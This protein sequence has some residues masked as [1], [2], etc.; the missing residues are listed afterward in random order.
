MAREIRQFKSGDLITLDE[1]V[2]ILE[3]IAVRMEPEITVKNKVTGFTHSGTLS[4]F[5][6]YRRLLLEPRAP[7]RPAGKRNRKPTEKP[8]VQT[9][10]LV[11]HVGQGDTLTTMDWKEGGVAG[12]GGG[13]GDGRQ[14]AGEAQAREVFRE[15]AEVAVGA[16][17]DYMRMSQEDWD[18]LHSASEE[19]PPEKPKRSHSKRV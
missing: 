15:G 6:D 2:T 9:D 4:E 3:I 13:A 16:G 7:G 14:E 1:G 12:E 17:G 11:I 18:K 8:P 5:Q 10:K 19:T